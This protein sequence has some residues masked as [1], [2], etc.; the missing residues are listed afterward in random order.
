MVRGGSAPALGLNGLK[1][2]FERAMWHH[3]S[4]H[5][6][7]IDGIDQIALIDSRRQLSFDKLAYATVQLA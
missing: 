4:S 1:N 7:Q 3:P 6:A 5:I 2:F